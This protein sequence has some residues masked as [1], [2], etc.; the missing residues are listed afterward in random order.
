METGNRKEIVR[1]VGFRFGS[2]RRVADVKSMN[3]V[4]SC[5]AQNLRSLS[6]EGNSGIR[7]LWR[8]VIVLLS[9]SREGPCVRL[10]LLRLVYDHLAALHHPADFADHHLYVRQRIAFD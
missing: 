10:D 7:F 9:A 4:E 8:S 6:S 1:N 2:L 3:S 5:S